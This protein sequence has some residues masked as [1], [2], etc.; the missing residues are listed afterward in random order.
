MSID[1]Y[2]SANFQASV[3]NIRVFVSLSIIV[4]RTLTDNNKMLEHDWLLT[5]LLYALIGCF[6]SKL[7]ESARPNQAV[8]HPGENLLKIFKDLQ[9]S[10]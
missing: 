7:S 9:G 4:R 8:K 5:A 3:C 1:N 10:L 6:R 2:R